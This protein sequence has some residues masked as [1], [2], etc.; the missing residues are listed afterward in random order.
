[1]V[2]NCDYSGERLFSAWIGRV[3][4]PRLRRKFSVTCTFIAYPSLTCASVAYAAVA[5]PSSIE[6]RD[7]AVLACFPSG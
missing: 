2:G 3:S 6:Q 7:T 1:V 4:K 5:Y